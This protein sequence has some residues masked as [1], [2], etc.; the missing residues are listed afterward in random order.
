MQ[1]DPFMFAINLTRHGNP[2][3]RKY[4]DNLMQNGNHVTD[5]LNKLRGKI[6][7]SSKSKFITYIDL[8]PSLCV[9]NVY[10]DSSANIPEL[11]I[12]SFS[13]FRLS[14]HRLQFRGHLRYIFVYRV[15]SRV[16]SVHKR[17][18]HYHVSSVIDRNVSA[19]YLW[20]ANDCTGLLVYYS[21]ISNVNELDCS[22][23]T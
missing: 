2:R 5:S 18:R 12:I 20:S 10:K 3:M 13:R 11:Y 9:H 16:I 6:C 21:I 4:L 17:Q 19:S 15:C 14:S 8:N 22:L 1:D 23:D 7:S